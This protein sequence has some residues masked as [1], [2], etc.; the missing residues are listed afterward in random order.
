MTLSNLKRELRWFRRRFQEPESR[1]G[2]IDK[3]E[4]RRYLPRHPVVVEA[5]AHQGTDTEEMSFMWPDATIHAFEPVPSLMESVQTRIGY[6]RNVRLYP[7]A[8]GAMNGRM[9]LNLSS[10]ASDASSS[11][12]APKRVSEF[13]PTVKFEQSIDV[14]VV[15]LADWMNRERV[16]RID[17]LWLD[18]QGAEFCV[19]EA[20]EKAL[21]HVSAVYC[22]V[23]L[24]EL[25]DGLKLY[26]EFRDW[27]CARGFRVQK[28]L[29][30][31]KDAGNV[32]FTR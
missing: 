16:S 32:L 17:L 10:G 5:G 31:W 12:L 30:A 23:N 3:R 24:V 7:M 20:S 22:E 1:E 27:L 9:V 19:L 25:Y 6:R 4:L 29:L 8:L 14:P 21:P 28:E 26:P 15:T 2:E 18:L 11:I 13:H